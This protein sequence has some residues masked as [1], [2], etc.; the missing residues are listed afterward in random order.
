[1]AQQIQPHSSPTTAAATMSRAVPKLVGAMLT[2]AAA[3]PPSEER[4]NDRKWIVVTRRKAIANCQAPS[5]KTSGTAIAITRKQVI[6]SNI[7][8]RGEV[9]VGGTLLE[10]YA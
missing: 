7:G 9:V 1:S 8:R 2:M 3:D 5:P 6:A 10:R 4:V